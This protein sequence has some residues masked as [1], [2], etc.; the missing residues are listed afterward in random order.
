[1]FKSLFGNSDDSDDFDKYSYE[2]KQ[3]DDRFMLRTT[4]LKIISTQIIYD[5]DDGVYYTIATCINESNEIET[6][7]IEGFKIEGMLSSLVGCNLDYE[8]FESDGEESTS[9]RIYMSN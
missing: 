1:M 7:N 2:E 8:E 9:G 3:T 5:S 6:I 4:T